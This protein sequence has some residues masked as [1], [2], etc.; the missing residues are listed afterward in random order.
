MTALNCSPISSSKWRSLFSPKQV[1]LL[2]ILRKKLMNILGTQERF[3][4]PREI[5]LGGDYETRYHNGLP[6]QMFVEWKAEF[7]SLADVLMKV[8][9]P[10]DEVISQCLKYQQLFSELSQSVIMLDGQQ[11]AMDRNPLANVD[12]SCRCNRFHSLNSVVF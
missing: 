7:I 9:L 1:S 3:V 11:L 5:L 4:H 10:S 12:T 2:W 8:I 6:Q